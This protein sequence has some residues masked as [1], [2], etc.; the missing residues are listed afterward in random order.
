MENSTIWKII[1]KYFD[2]NP[3]CLVRHHTESYNDFF[4]NGIFQIFKEKN[5]IRISTRFDEKLNDYRSQCIM[6]FGGKEGN[7]IYFGKPIIYDDDDNS[8]YMYPNEARLRNMTYG[9]TIHYDVD[10]EFID[11]LDKDELPNIVGIENTGEGDENIHTE[12]VNF[13]TNHENEQPALDYSKVDIAVDKEITGG[14]VKRKNKPKRRI[15][16]ELSPMEMGL[17]REAT[18]K[19]MTS[20]NRQVRTLTL[21]KIFLGKFPI[22]VQSEYCVLSGLPREVRHTMGECRNDVG[23]YFIIDGK[24]KTVVSQ[25]KFGDNMLYI[26]KSN[27]DVSLYS[28]EIRSVS[29]NVAKPIRTLSVRIMAPSASYSNKNIVVNIPNVRKPVPLFIVFRALGVISDK[30]IITMCLLDL[31]K[32]ESMVDLFAPSVH[33]AG[34]IM[35]QRTAL[36]YI[37]TLT[38]RKTVPYVLEILSDYFLP[39]VGETNYIQKSYYLGHIVFKLLSVYTGLEVPT[40]RDNFKFKRIELVGSLMYDLFREYYTIQQRQIHLAFESKI[41]FNRNL[42]ENNLY[43]LIQEN[44]KAFFGER[45]LESGFK[46]AFKGNWGAFTHTKRIGVVQD[47]NR[48]SH[49]SA[50]SHLRKTNLPLDASVKLVGPRVLHNTQWGLFDPIDTPDGG[51]IGIHKHIS[52]SAYVTQGVSREPMIKWLRENIDMKLLE[53]CTP[54]VLSTMTKV[55][56]N[57][58]WAGSITTPI[59]SVEKIRLFRRNAL[60]PIYTSVTFDIKQNTVFIYTDAGRL[61]RPIFYRDTETGKMSFDNKF[62]KDR[63]EDNDFTWNDLIS[64]FNE[65]KIENFNPNNYKMYQLAELYK[66]ITEES[67][68]AKLNKFLEGKAILDYLDT[69]EAENALIAMNKEDLTKDSKRKHTHMEIHESLIF[70]MMCNIGIFPENNPA[71]RNSFSCGQSKQACSMYHTNHQVRMD[72]T[73]VVLV[74]GQ[75]P[76][77]KSRYLEH[78]NHEENTYGENAIVAIMCYT[79]YNVEDA[80]LINEGALKRGLFRTTYYTTYETHEEKSKSGD[81]TT[82]KIFT[83]IDSESTVIGTKPGYDYSKLDKYGLIRENTPVDDKTVLIG[84]TVTNSNMKDTKMDMSKTP[85]KG[86]L[87]IVDKSFIT[88]GE[89]GNR[90]A[91][92]RIREERIPNI[93][94]KM[95]CALPTQQ[96]LTNIGWIEIKDIDIS[97]HKVAT[98]DVNGNMCYEYPVNKFEYDHDGQMYFIQ[99]KQAHVICTLNHKLY[100][101]KRHGKYYELIEAENV[102]GKMV[103][104][105]KSMKNILPDVEFMKLGDKQYKMDD[106]LQLL[107]M[108]IGDGSVNNRAVILSCHKERKV[109]FNISLLTKLDIEYKYDNYN[110]YFAINIG[111]YPEI[112]N[113]LKQYNLGALNKYLPEYVWSLSQRQSIILLESLLQS[114][115]HTYN[116]GFSRYGTISLRLANDVSRLAV[117]CGWSGVIK[118]AAEPDGKERLVTGKLGYNKGKTHTIIQKHTYYKISIIRKQNQ[119][120]I[121]KKVNES[122]VEKLIDYNGKV[123]CIEMPSSH[124]YYMRETN[125]APSMLIGNSRAGQKGTVGLVVPERDMPFTKD[126]IRPDIII[127]PHAIPT[128]MTIGQ[129]VETIV[130]K[131]SAMYGGY[132]DCT[133]F[134]NRGSK[135]GVFGEMLTKVGYHSSGNEILYNGMTGEQIETEIFIGPNYYMRLK[136][137]VK[138]KINYR[139]LGPRSALTRQTVG[140]RANDGGLR[141]GEMERDSVISHGT[142]EFLRESMME[143]GDKYK[144]A[145]CNT[146]GLV[147]IYN[148]AKNV[149]MSPLA[150]GPLKFI[151]SMDGNETHIENISKYG[152][153]FSII[154]VPYSLKL[155]IQELQTINVQ[156]RII[157]EDNIQQLENMSFSKNINLLTAD[158]KIEPKDIINQIKKAISKSGSDALNTPE[159]IIEN[160]PT[161]PELSP[162]YPDTSPAYETPISPN[163]PPYPE[164]SPAYEGPESPPYEPTSP[165][166]PPFNPFE[167]DNKMIGGFNNDINYNI[168]EPVYYRGDSS[169]KRLWKIIDIGN[170][171]ITIEANTNEYLGTND[172]VQVVLPSDI[173]RPNEIVDTSIIN[174]PL[175]PTS[176]LYNSY[177]QV[178]YPTQPFMGQSTMPYP[179]IN[180]KVVSGNDF[181]TNDNKN[182]MNMSTE[183][184]NTVSTQESFGI[185]MNNDVPAAIKI[186]PNLNNESNNEDIKPT[187]DIDFSKGGMIIVK[188]G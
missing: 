90:I 94:D 7:K 154:S 27:D 51:N 41:T 28:A 13:K 158:E 157:T 64:G 1:D 81:G 32:Y 183:P 102:M 60:L 136:H 76:L 48:L 19:S 133:A 174:E 96:V 66:N 26:R 180:I 181:S 156:M 11:I 92:I 110:G 111:K 61:C 172:T 77:V 175:Q 159:S 164:T 53:D 106:W 107:G 97:V 168:G 179:P 49:N 75:V 122:N 166:S 74:N 17:L 40:D 91:K 117:H 38:K 167:N 37:A 33:D 5:P 88:D 71:T 124:L 72:K 135:I 130:G 101:K 138:D 2:D 118:I 93:G 3:Q 52:I 152:R 65:K 120:Y 29:E 129:L 131:A 68:P 98:L 12:F 84:L 34:G 80:I 139:A 186:N 119:P 100:V 63:L 59:E 24:E 10:I 137:M 141:I 109:N 125:F 147:A 161:S 187:N 171:F 142:A 95:A 67:N 39:H 86:Q 22:M 85:K 165:S 70:G 177:D 108:F 4:K 188:K 35:T 43:G 105:Q 99:N 184:T 126:G 15:D 8:H 20:S 62:I 47:L 104:F 150:D 149:F 162:P 153:S 173:Y 143:R 50:L 83:N 113:E 56:I 36:K 82:E 182:D 6:Y 148:P 16:L 178:N 30:Q 128:R 42:Y 115:G 55:M 89:E 127:N 170:Q 116:D 14:A 121:N 103:R 57:G 132:A 87:G 123:Y 163:S 146:T 9:M 78:I 114:D 144:L 69:N 25:E 73:S 18:E 112:Y 155:L 58:L 79:G 140:G 151:T 134:N 31:E 44:Y 176:G 46:K 21:E 145:I 160:I 23:G 45:S 54:K 185:K 169:P